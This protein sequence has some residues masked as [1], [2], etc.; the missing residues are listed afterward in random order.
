MGK[1]VM[2]FEIWPYF[3]SCLILGKLPVTSLCLNMTH[4]GKIYCLVD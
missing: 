3:M 1:Q 4:T 2:D